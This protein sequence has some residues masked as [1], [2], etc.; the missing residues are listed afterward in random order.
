MLLI[1]YVLIS[2]MLKLP[3]I[4]TEKKRVMMAQSSVQIVRKKIF[5]A[6]ECCF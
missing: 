3:M 5:H 1:D 4:P 6:R 2:I